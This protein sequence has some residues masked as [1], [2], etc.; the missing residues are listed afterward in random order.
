MVRSV[1]AR[2]ISQTK[3]PW[4]HP[5]RHYQTV[6][7]LSPWISVSTA[8]PWGLH[9]DTRIA[10]ATAAAIFMAALSLT[11]V[12]AV[13][14]IH[15]H[16][17]LILSNRGLL[18]WLASIMTC[19]LSVKPFPARLRIGRHRCYSVDAGTTHTVGKMNGRRTTVSLASCATITPKSNQRTPQSIARIGLEPP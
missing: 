5:R 15:A 1:M 10:A 14:A 2:S 18:C 4:K 9:R 17:R 19:N 3:T 16:A 12:I 8:W 6:F 7:E 13:S 11:T